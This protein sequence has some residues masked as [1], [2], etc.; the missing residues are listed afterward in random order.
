MRENYYTVLKTSLPSSK[1]ENA[2][3]TIR[4]IEY[5]DTE[6][7]IRKEMI[8]NQFSVDSTVIGTNIS[9]AGTIFGVLGVILS[10]IAM[11]QTCVSTTDKKIQRVENEMATVKTDVKV[12]DSLSRC[13]RKM[14][15]RH[16]SIQMEI[17]RKLDIVLKDKKMNS[18]SE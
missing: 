18:K 14:G 11:C 2:K 6:I 8:N 7:R 4:K 17:I 16:D 12:L 15:Q 1:T 3:E 10:A 13:T 5:I 9:T